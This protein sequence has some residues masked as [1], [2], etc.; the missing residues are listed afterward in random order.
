MAR[1]VTENAEDLRTI[2][3]LAVAGTYKVVIDRTWPLEE[4]SEAHRYVDTGRKRGNM[5]IRVMEL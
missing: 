4:M 5:A 3:G 2:A 1:V